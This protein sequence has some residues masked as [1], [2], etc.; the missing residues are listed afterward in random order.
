MK[1]KF[2]LMLLA[3][4]SLLTGAVIYYKS[5]NTSTPAVVGL[6]RSITNI[7]ELDP[8]NQLLVEKAVNRALTVKEINSNNTSTTTPELAPAGKME[9]K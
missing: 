3:I 9:S 1:N 2:L 5:A 7:L 4:G 8:H 6:S